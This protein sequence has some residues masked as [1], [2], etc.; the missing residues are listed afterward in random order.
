MTWRLV[1]DTATHRTVIA[2]GR[3]RTLAAGVVLEARDRHGARLLSQLTSVLAEAG[4]GMSDVT[5]IGVGTGPGS[6]TGLRVGLATAKTLAAIHHLPLVGLPTDEALRQAA[7]NESGTSGWADAAVLLPAGAR[8]HYLGLP[9]SDPVLVPPGTDLTAFV[10]ARPVVAVDVAADAGW[11]VPLREAATARGLPDP[12][13]LGSAACEGLPRAL[14]EL[15]DARLA[16]GDVADVATLVPRYVALP[17]GIRAVT[18]AAADAFEPSA[19]GEGTWSPGF[20]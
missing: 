3:G 18:A 16:R 17:R 4:I 15:L 12:L 14:L 5:A 7:A 19:A 13:D 6:F 1:I 10:G 11:L 20:R 2:L 9:G 8:D